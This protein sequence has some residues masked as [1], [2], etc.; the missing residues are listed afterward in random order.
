[1]MAA[2]IDFGWRAFF[3]VCQGSWRHHPS[4]WKRWLRLTL[5]GALLTGCS[6]WIGPPAEIQYDSQAT[7]QLMH[8]LL[9][10]NDGLEAIKGLGRVTVTTDGTAHTYE[11]AVWVGATPGR[12]RFVF[13]APTGMPVFSM[14]CDAE[15]LTA[16]NYSDG[17]YYRHQ[18]GDNSLS[19]Y[20]PV[21]IKCA[22]LYALLVNRPPKVA[23]D[24][25]RLDTAQS[26]DN[27]SL[28]LLLRRRFR[29]TVGRIRVDRN[30]GA[31][32][33][34][35]LLDIHGNRLYEARLQA[36]KTIDGYRLPTR[37]TLSGLDGS[38][39]LDVRR[40]WPE[41]SVTEDL[42]QIAPPQTE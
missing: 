14:S 26:T 16:L 27:D 19:R 22:D 38:L 11:R 24:A 42:F 3:R 25:V 36:I 6:G 10:A 29:G 5:L 15:W 7:Q 4:W 21:S 34:V 40:C 31:L 32:Q 41:S 39:V 35:E 33:A 8:Q 37:I 23:Y 20:L 30:T 9:A 18:I 28:V 2:S 13:Q 17:R 12:L 1:M